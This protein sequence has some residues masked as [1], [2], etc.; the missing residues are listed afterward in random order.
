MPPI[1]IHPHRVEHAAS[2]RIE[3]AYKA[4]GPDMIPT[5]LLKLFAHQLAPALT[6]PYQ[7]SLD[8]EQLP[9]DWRTA[10][11]LPILRRVTDLSPPI[12]GQYH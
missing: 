11:V 2:F 1:H 8:Q 6:V 3:V 12:I 10:N 7:A 5:Y 4:S 9:E